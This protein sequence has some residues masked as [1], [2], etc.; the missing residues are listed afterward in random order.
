M[1]ITF[2]GTGLRAGELIGLRADSI[3]FDN[4]QIRAIGIGAKERNVFMSAAVY[5]VLFKY[6]Y[7]WRPKVASDYF[8]VLDSG[9]PLTRFYIAHRLAAYGRKAKISDVRVSAYTLR[10]SFAVNFL[11]NE[12]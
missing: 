6:F 8:S 5:K 11:R 12:R 4:G 3:N 7:H 2:Y 1:V 10:H 9:R